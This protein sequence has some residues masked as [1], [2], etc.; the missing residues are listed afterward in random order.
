MYKVNVYAYDKQTSEIFNGC[1]SLGKTKIQ[2]ITF[3]E[4]TEQK[5]KNFMCPQ[6]KFIYESLKYANEHEYTLIC[7]DKLV[8]LCDSR[9]VYDYLEYII[10]NINFDI[11]YLANWADRCDLYSDIH[12]VDNFKIVK[13]L[14]PHG[15]SCLLFSPS[16]RELFLKHVKNTTRHTIDTILNT[17]NHLFRTYTSLP[18]IVEFDILKR[19]S[20]LEFVKV[21]K[22]REVPS[23]IHPIGITRRNTSTLN[24]FWF[25]L[26]LIIIICVAALL[27]TLS[28]QS[29]TDIINEKL[30]YPYFPYDPTGNI[31]KRS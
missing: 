7:L 31:I 24:V 29:Y 3:C 6:D 8:S 18:C 27:L 22:A 15:T 14:S 30:V 9:Q 25:I 5:C 10:E 23:T 16:G 26:V 4:F 12:E 13:T 19:N 1:S 20:D 11:F 21:C 2:D 17:N 28:P